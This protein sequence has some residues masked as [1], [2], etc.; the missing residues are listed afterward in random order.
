MAFVHLH[1]HTEHSTLDGASRIKSVAKAAAA[2]GQ[3]AMA[4]TDHG[5]LAGAWRFTKACKAAGIKPIIG[6]E[7]YMSIGS[8]FERNSIV[9][10][11]N[12]DTVGDADEGSGK[13][14]VKRYEHL[15]VL[16]RTQQGWKNLLA[17]H[18]KAEDSY[19]YKPRIDYELL[20]EHGEGLIVLTGC[21]AG[22]IAGPLS[23]AASED[24]K[25]E[26]A[27][28]DGFRAEARKNLDT[29]IDCVGKEHVFLEIMDHGIGA[30]RSVLGPIKDLSV[31]YG[32]P[33]VVTNDCHYEHEDHAAVHDG[34]LA[35]GVGRNLDDPSR[36]RFNGSGY[37]V[38]SEEEMRAIRPNSQAW[39]DAVS[40]SQVIADM[41]E[42]QVIPE[43]H[44][45]LPKYP[46]PEGFDDSNVYLKHLVKDGSIN[47]Y[48]Y[49]KETGERIALSE[50]VKER[51]KTELGIIKDM[52]FPDYFLIVW[53]VINWCRSDAPIEFDNQDAPRKKPILVGPGRGSAA[54]SAVSYCLGIVGIDPLYN[55]L[56]F[57]RFLEPGRAGMPDI[58]VDFEKGRRDE[59]F[60]YL[61][62]RWGK[63]NVARIGT[64]GVALAKAAIQDAARILKPTGASPEARA[65]A[66][67]LFKAG[68]RI[69][70]AKL[71]KE[72]NKAA[73][74]RG[75]HLL[76]LGNKMSA[77]VPDAGEKTYDFAQLADTRDLAGQAFR[78]LV[79]A[80]GQDAQDILELARGFEG[81][82]K[83]ESIHA[84]GFVV[85]P[86]P[87]DELVPL[88]YSSHAADADPAAPRVI[89]WDG[90]E[91]E[92]YGFLKMDILGLMNLDIVSQA[93]ENIEMT[94][95]EHLTMDGIPHPDTK[96][97]PKVEAAFALIAAGN[98]AGVFQ[99]ESPGMIKIA[100]DVVPDS[101]TDISAIVALFR[102]G[103]LAAK[104]P[105]RY[106]ARKNGL[107]EVDYDQFTSNKMEQKWIAKVLG[108]TYGV[109]VFQES[110]MRLGT[111]ISGF[112]ASQRSVLRKAV[113][114]KDAK[115]MA[116]VGQM[117]A[118]G[119]EQ[120]FFDEDGN[121]ISPKFSA[122]T[123]THMFELMKGS[124]SYLFNASHSA[125]YAHLAYV[126]A[127]LKA[128]WPVEYGAA[129]LSVVDT[130]KPEKR[131]TALQSLHDDGITVLAPDLNLAQ[132]R[133]APV[134]NCVFI[135]L[136]EV[137]DVG[138]A[139]VHIVAEREK[140]GPFT[141]LHDLLT[142]VTIPGKNGGYDTKLPSGAVV[143]LIEAGAMDSLGP[144]LGLLM[145][146]R[147]A[148]KTD[149]AP[150]NAEWSD[151][152][153]STRQRVRLGVSLGTHPLTSLKDELAAWEAPGGGGLTPLH[154]IASG[155][156]APVQ[157]VG[158]ISGWTEKG[159]SGGR[160]ANFALESSK[161]TIRGVIWDNTLS[162]LNRQGNVPKIGDVVAMSGK[163]N[164]R[165]TSVGDEESGAQETITTK[166][167]NISEVWPITS[168]EAPKVEL[169]GT[170]ID[171]ANE[172]KR[173][174]A[175]ELA[176][177]RAKKAAA[178][179][180][181]EAPDP[182]DFAP[183]DASAG[184]ADGPGDEDFSNV[185]SL[186]EHR[187]RH[188]PQW[189][190]VTADEF[191][192][193]I[194]GLEIIDGDKDLQR[195]YDIEDLPLKGDALENGSILRCLTTIGDR[196]F[197]IAEGG[198]LNPAEM[199]EIARRNDEV[200][201]RWV[202]IQVKESVATK[203]R[204]KCSWSKMVPE[205]ASGAGELLA[206]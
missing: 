172:F 120:E 2:H 81:L 70:G 139:A 58:D 1:N 14:K 16:A 168:G 99:M 173:L 153:E 106:A 86:E 111:V 163:V 96:N 143:G 110:L 167:L 40:Q 85:S 157:T 75:S 185:V 26:T 93:L 98:T 159:Y 122:K 119:A 4:I 179:P 130:N 183:D 134:N 76:R 20:K 156:G 34:F 53:D 176:P 3:T 23:R 129:I 100:Q 21:L 22:P 5:P 205:P 42:D 140:N 56:L 10:D 15:T 158:V 6:V 64:F 27:N 118:A 104:V 196:I 199:L 29:L 109:F 33:M 138:A 152:E 73:E 60:A 71:L 162:R 59:V 195:A 154:K 177:A 78:D 92:D 37:H 126:T 200:E 169:G 68:D 202:P 166:E 180:K 178:G 55:N 193:I 170:V 95:G 171:F 19:W 39:Q 160:R 189:L 197:V 198:S 57:E 35:V 187:S 47:R 38:K 45:R 102:P 51:L 115:K 83:N 117:L 192:H 133:T 191:S 190:G 103:P 46:L 54:G 128:N 49:D 62:Y 150:I 13:E 31:E 201:D 11:S 9:V 155:N 184:Q 148:H 164:V 94:T 186:D 25:G 147:A 181:A 50:E 84:C 80:E 116:E 194:G 141:S 48:G 188:V 137:R 91:V 125:A 67:E 142:R 44:M 131:L 114:K 28:A 61:G 66:D 182:E 149:L 18:N 24:A 36:F 136:A 105:D 12:D 32:I 204:P 41:C 108:D 121:M 72:A 63:G 112:D 8:R 77:L 161:V 127:Y 107:E 89:C 174:R 65:A 79:E 52:G 69:A 146:A 203:N 88:R 144:R 90:P 113:G 87:L 30:E 82:T 175:V 101:L 132:A 123:A 135:G 145:T 7:F 97:D 165:T 206:S 74:D 17:L 43:P 151:V 124:A